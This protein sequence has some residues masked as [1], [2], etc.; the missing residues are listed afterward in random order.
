MIQKKKTTVVQTIF[1]RSSINLKKMKRNKNDQ[2]DHF[3]HWLLRKKLYESAKSLLLN[4]ISKER[5][6]ENDKW[7]E[8]GEAW[9]VFSS[10]KIHTSYIFWFLRIYL[11]SSS[12]RNIHNIHSFISHRL[13]NKYTLTYILSL[14]PSTRRL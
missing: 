2:Q 8:V 10:W 13:R 12:N 11:S 14:N 9:Y 6:L 3:R 4:E 7:I 1:T 5:G